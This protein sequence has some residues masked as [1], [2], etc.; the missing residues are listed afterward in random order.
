MHDSR[1]SDSTPPF[2]ALIAA[3]ARRQHGV[4]SLAQLAELGLGRGSIAHRV[5]TGRLHRVH[6]AVYA[7]GHPILSLDGKFMAATLACGDGA[8]LSH[9]AG[10]ALHGL[11]KSATARIEVSCARRCQPSRSLRPHQTRTLAPQDI[12]TVEGIP[13]TSVARTLLDLADVAPARQAERALHQ[14]EIL[15]VFD[16]TALDDVLARANGRRGA[17]A[18]RQA[19]ELHRRAPA[20]TRS[21]L[22]DAFLALVDAAALPRPLMNTPLHGFTVDAYW[23]EHGVVVELDSYKYHRTRRVFESD[24]RRDIVLQNAGLRTARVTDTRIED[25][26]DIVVRD[27]RALVDSRRARSS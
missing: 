25:E 4:V 5:K 13:V 17:R 3:L 26:P 27:L 23:P 15:G 18:L 20:L 11:L 19:L 2:D 16:L 14:A 7:V 6:R 12:T 21:G 24:R 10:A 22:E 8:V 9:R 1:A